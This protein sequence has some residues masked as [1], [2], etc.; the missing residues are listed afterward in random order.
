MTKYERAGYHSRSLIKPKPTGPENKD[1]RSR[2]E[3][4]KTQCSV[5]VTR[6][7]TAKPVMHYEKGKGYFEASG[8]KVCSK[9]EMDLRLARFYGATND[10]S[11]FTRLRI[12]SRASAQ[13]LNAAFAAGQGGAL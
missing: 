8:A 13:S 5:L 12:E 3:P 4:V 9:R 11:A 7:A 1:R 2:T 6:G 10:L